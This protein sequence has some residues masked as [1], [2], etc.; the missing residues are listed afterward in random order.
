MAVSGVRSAWAASAV[1]R[2]TRNT[3]ARMRRS[4]SFSTAASRS[5]SSPEPV[6]GSVPSGRLPSARA[7]AAIRAIGSSARAATKY[8]ESA[9]I[10]AISTSDVTRFLRRRPVPALHLLQ[11]HADPHVPRPDPRLERA[12]APGAAPAA[13]VRRTPSKTRASAH[14]DLRR[15]R[16]AGLRHVLAARDDSRRRRRGSRRRARPRARCLPV[17][18]SIQA[19]RWSRPEHDAQLAEI[20]RRAGRRSPRRSRARSATARRR[21]AARP[22]STTTVKT[23]SAIR[24]RMLRFTGWR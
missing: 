8:A 23:A 15:A 12:H 22:G 24:S 7:C 20:L 19:S 17:V 1:R 11:A 16:E 2:R 13:R 3:S 18:C 21:S 14:R 4:R 9:P 6:R 5:T 10:S